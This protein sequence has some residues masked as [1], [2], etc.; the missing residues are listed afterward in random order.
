MCFHFSGTNSYIKAVYDL[1]YLINLRFR[2]FPYHSDFIFS[3]SPHGFKYRKACRVAH[4][5]TGKSCTHDNI[6]NNFQLLM[7][8]KCIS[9]PYCMPTAWV[10][11]QMFI[12]Y[13]VFWRGSYEKE[14]R[15]IKGR[16]RNGPCKG[17]EKLGL[18]GHP[19]LCK[20]MLCNIS[21][22]L[23][24]YWIADFVELNDTGKKV[25]QLFLYTNS[26]NVKIQS[27]IYK[28]T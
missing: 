24:F 13:F 11:L 20:S 26:Q 7:V 18:P 6:W 5:H 17:Q 22:N 16:E 9:L 8:L 19:S 4:S 3:L 27:A 23:R 15:S 28:N 21:S 14:K 10:S 12:H 2:T 1:S 25:S